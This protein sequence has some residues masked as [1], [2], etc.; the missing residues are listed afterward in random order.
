M[1]RKIAYGEL[2]VLAEALQRME[3]LT[4]EAGF[5][6]AKT[7]RAINAEAGIFAELRNN[8]V[9]KYGKTDE[10]GG[11]SVKPGDENW[12]AFLEE[13]TAL[14]T[15]EAEVELSQVARFDLDALYCPSAKASDY[16]IFEKYMVKEPE[17]EEEQD[18]EA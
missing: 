15:K 6:I 16:D 9:K 10:R 18:G 12:N 11:I 8:L 13:Y 17:P 14:Y 2:D 1:K 7:K 3:G 5:A 4:G